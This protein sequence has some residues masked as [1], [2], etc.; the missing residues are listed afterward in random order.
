MTRWSGTW[1]PLTERFPMLGGDELRELA[2][3]IRRHGQSAPCRMDPKGLGL[4]GRSRVAACALAGV[5]PRWEVYDGDPVAFVVEANAEDRNLSTGQRAMAVAIGLVEAGSRRNGRFRRG[6]VPEHPPALTRASWRDKVALAGF[7]LD[8]AP[9]LGDRVLAGE[10]GLD[11]AHK[12]A[13]K[14]RNHAHSGG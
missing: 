12:L 5:E 8:H 7:V 1:H 10:L 14:Q 13:G 11:T 4:D 3:S 2:A 6:S 9:D